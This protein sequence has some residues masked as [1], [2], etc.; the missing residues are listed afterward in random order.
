MKD[1]VELGM[2]LKE[3]LGSNNC[4][5]SPPANIQI[6]YP[7][8]V[9]SLSNIQTTFA[10]NIPYLK[11]KRYTLTLIDENPD[12]EIRDKLSDLP[13]CTF[14]RSFVSDG[15]NHYIFTIFWR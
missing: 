1:R 9:Y 5:F 8:I 4:Y 11:N 15:L 6:K 2:K 12:S 3:I 14:D 7:C 13:C 10:D